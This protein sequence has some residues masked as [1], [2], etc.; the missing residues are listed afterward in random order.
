M[1]SRQPQRR[2][3]TNNKK[4]FVPS[5]FSGK[6][7]NGLLYHFMNNSGIFYFPSSFRKKPLPPSISVMLWRRLM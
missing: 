6:Q 5:P 3:K 7:P 4:P 2:K 1:K